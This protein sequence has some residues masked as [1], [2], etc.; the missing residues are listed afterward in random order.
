MVK[1]KETEMR[2]GI[3]PLTL[4][5]CNGGIRA[6][7]RAS[8]GATTGAA[9][10]LCALAGCGGGGGDG[11]TTTS[12]G[13]HTGT[14]DADTIDLVDRGDAIKSV[15]AGAGND[16]I[17][18]GI[19]EQ[20]I[21]GGAGDD[22]IDGG[23]GEDTINGGDGDDTLT[24]GVGDDTIDGGAGDR[25][26]AVYSG[27][28]ADYRVSIV[29]GEGGG[30]ARFLV[31]H[32]TDTDSDGRDT[33]ANVE[34]IQFGAAAAVAL[35]ANL[36]SGGVPVGVARGAPMASAVYVAGAQIAAIDVSMFFD[37]AD[38]VDATY[39]IEGALPAGLVFTA[40]TGMLIGR[41][42]MASTTITIIASHVDGATY[43][44]VAH[45]YVIAVAIDPST[46][47]GGETPRPLS[48]EI[49]PGQKFIVGPGGVGNDMNMDFISDGINAARW[50]S[51]GSGELTFTAALDG[52]GDLSEIGL[53]ISETG[54]IEGELLNHDNFNEIIISAIDEAGQSVS[55][56]LAIDINHAPFHGTEILNTKVSLGDPIG[57]ESGDGIP[58]RYRFTDR[59]GD[60]LTFEAFLPDGRG[61][62]E[63]G[64][65]IDEDDV[66]QGIVVGTGDTT[67]TVVV[68]DGYG[69]ESRAEFSI[70]VNENPIPNTPATTLTAGH[71][72][73]IRLGMRENFN[74]PDG[75]EM[76]F[77]AST[78]GEHATLA[79]IGLALDGDSGVLSG[80]FTGINSS[81]ITI[82]AHDGRGGSGEH[83]VILTGDNA[84][85]VI[86]R[87]IT[88][89]IA[90]VGETFSLD[91]SEELVTDIDGAVEYGLFVVDRHG[92]AIP[93]ELAPVDG[94]PF[95]YDG[96]TL[97]FDADVPASYGGIAWDLVATA[98]GS[99]RVATTEFRLAVPLPTGAT[100]SLPFQFTEARE[101]GLGTDTHD[102]FNP[103]NGVHA[104]IDDEDDEGRG[105]ESNWAGDGTFNQT[106]EI[107]WSFV[108]TG[109]EFNGTEYPEKIPVTT[110]F[111][112][113]DKEFV[114]ETIAHI[115]SL[116]GASFEEVEDNGRTDRGDIAIITPLWEEAG[117]VRTQLLALA[118]KPRNIDGLSPKE[119]T[120]SDKH[121]HWGDILIPRSRE[122]TNLYERNYSDARS[123]FVHE[124]MH[125]MGFNDF[126]DSTLT[127]LG[128]E[129]VMPYSNAYTGTFHW[130]P[131]SG[132]LPA[133]E[134]VE[135]VPWMPGLY[136]IATLQ[137]LYGAK[138][139]SNAGNNVYE[140]DDDTPVFEVIWD[141]GGVDTI[142]QS[143]DRSAVID[144]NP[145][146]RSTLGFH[147]GRSYDMSAVAVAMSEHELSAERSF[148]A[149]WRTLNFGADSEKWVYSLSNDGEIATITPNLTSIGV[150]ENSSVEYQIEL[151]NG[152][153]I[154]GDWDAETTF[155]DHD[156]S[157]HN[158]AIALGVV[159]EN[160]EGGGGDDRI[161]GNF[162]DNSLTG[163]GGNDVFVITRDP[164][165]GMDAITDF[166]PGEDMIEFVHFQE[167]DVEIR[168]AGSNAVFSSHGMEL[169][170]SGIQTMD[171]EAGVDYVFVEDPRDVTLI[172]NGNVRHFRRLDDRVSVDGDENLVSTGYG[173]DT[174]TASGDRNMLY[175]NRDDDEISVTGNHNSI[176][177]Y[178]GNNQIEMTGN[179]NHFNGTGDVIISGS[180][181][182]VDISKR[183]SSQ[184]DDSTIT[185][186]SGSGHSIFLYE[187]GTTVKLES[188]A[189]QTRIHDFEV[190]EDVVE[191]VGFD[192]E[193]FTSIGLE[194]VPNSPSGARHFVFRTEDGAVF[195]SDYT[196]TFPS[197]TEG[198]DYFFI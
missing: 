132:S 186:R 146:G 24:G 136:D 114:R 141:G 21:D 36:V 173:N 130:F 193:D 30:P 22:T 9:A 90:T 168:E 143:G 159:I 125:S 104:L 189:G 34:M 10:A 74:E 106:V 157:N 185:I 194:D 115:D 192:R 160:A 171:L 61:I 45:E 13:S 140:F 4:P 177:D 3:K 155:R 131:R 66:I 102:R 40:A 148:G 78:G 187:S 12:G 122:E 80:R 81:P 83:R 134:L 129:S 63:I 57:E 53:S 158:V 105:F 17:N 118:F 116:I 103:I 170:L 86:Q 184:S 133:P 178:Y 167:S 107:T 196:S 156:N 76:T 60:S 87:D 92:S 51:G 197:L 137:H 91:I 70:D 32:E 28:R 169:T 26:V 120:K 18:T 127:E 124:V 191:F 153:T 49:P 39:G 6:G 149:T 16:T 99:G 166:T 72:D 128:M 2:D 38:G 89:Q 190:G 179:S 48:V 19:G 93:V 126:P 41:A 152:T 8:F 69:G 162:A 94:V 1:N 77:T 15:D 182:R 176:I 88:D 29:D 95:T 117:V 20:T 188:V 96:T 54:L 163:G 75:D 14:S 180:E 108:D 123:T 183:L 113:S 109:S 71:A 138:V 43:D 35:D 112:Q 52:G 67:V 98:A 79:S 198:A 47:G 154:N 56:I 150:V 174:I 100:S 165:A 42:P 27:A 5:G 172:G 161:I 97:S 11:G 68:S 147:G 139:E 65:N 44:D 135:L 195:F 62:D 84:S 119:T 175:G 110:E 82:Y 25:D 37:V 144:L 46:N 64:L 101:Y 151:M 59:D 7:G 50:F 111:S 121:N 55:A 23:A 85:A 142:V 31:L 181:G 164:V 58:L 145:A 73:P 33:L